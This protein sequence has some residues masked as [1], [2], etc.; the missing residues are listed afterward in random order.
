MF[1]II[2]VKFEFISEE[3]RGRAWRVELVNRVFGFLGKVDLV[4]VVI[5]EG[6]CFFSYY[7]ISFF[8]LDD[9]C[10]YFICC[11]RV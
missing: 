3:G 7:F 2:F 5:K 8:R 4:L 9:M 10:V 11:L 1:L 6:F